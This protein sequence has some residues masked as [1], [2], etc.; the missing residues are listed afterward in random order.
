MRE[1][2]EPTADDLEAQ[3]DAVADFVED[4]VSVMGIDAIA[5]PNEANGRMYVD[6]VDAAPEDLAVLLG[7]DGETLDAIQELARQVVGHQLDQRIRVIVDVHDHR[8]RHEEALIGR[9]E[10]LADEVLADGAERELEPMHALDR[11]IVHDA[12]AEIDGVETLSRGEEP[13]RY[14]VV[15]PAPAG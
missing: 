3:A 4:L 5:E 9:A 6:V 14:V 12:L 10:A 11:K 2:Q 7:P 13:H 1:R 15:R 8:K